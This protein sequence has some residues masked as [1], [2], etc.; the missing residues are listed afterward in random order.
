MDYKKCNGYDNGIC[1]FS[2]DNCNDCINNMRLYSI[3][4]LQDE[5]SFSTDYYRKLFASGKIPAYKVDGVWYSTKE[6][7]VKYVEEP[8]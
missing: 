4:E 8:K 5:V 2:G 1:K 7:V 3:K 6:A